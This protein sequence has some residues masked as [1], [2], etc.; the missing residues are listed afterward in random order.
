M[1]RGTCKALFDVARLVEVSLAAESIP[2]KVS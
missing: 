2:L 1:T